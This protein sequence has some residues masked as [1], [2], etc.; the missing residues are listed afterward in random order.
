VPHEVGDAAT[1]ESYAAS[2][3]RDERLEALAA[4]VA[5]LR[6]EVESLR[7]QL[8]EFRSQFEN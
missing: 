1:G 5:Q 6:A 2:A 8:T 3:G 7:R 4:E